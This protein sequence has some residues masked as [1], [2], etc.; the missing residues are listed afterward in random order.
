[1]ANN[2]KPKDDPFEAILSGSNKTSK[3]DPF[4]AILSGS[5][6][7]SPVPDKPSIPM[8]ALEHYGNTLSGGYLPHLQASAAPYMDKAL[9]LVTGNNVAKADALFPEKN[10]Y[11]S[12]RDENIARLKAEELANPKTALAA[13]A[14]GIVN[15][16]ALLPSA[17]GVKGGIGLGAALG[18]AQNPGDAPGIVDPIQAGDR[19]VNAG[20]GAVVGGT[21]GAAGN[22]LKSRKAIQPLL[23]TTKDPL[24]F[25]TMANGEFQN[26]LEKM[27]SDVI[28]P[29]S[30][31]LLQRIKGK[32]VKINPDD[33]ERAGFPEEA[34]NLRMAGSNSGVSGSQWEVP[35][36]EALRLKQKLDA[37][38]NWG[39]L[40]SGVDVEA[41]Q[42]QIESI[43]KAANDLR[44]QINEIPGAKRLN[45][46]LHEA[47]ALRSRVTEASRR[48]VAGLIT[49]ATDNLADM[50]RFDE[51]AGT[52][53]SDTAKR[54]ATA[55]RLSSELSAIH[56]FRSAINSAD[57]YGT[58]A[59]KYTPPVKALT[60]ISGQS[61]ATAAATSDPERLRS[62][63]ISPF[64]LQQALS[65][66][67]RGGH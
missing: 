65:A 22:Y 26:A 10:S 35:A 14:A 13:K 2:A 41:N 42:N 6:A 32:T 31:A 51:L 62:E 58:Q 8:T 53:L 43:S 16:A 17:G 55:K 34:K 20:A 7:V 23:E 67:I 1:M 49:K 25:Q 63:A 50:Q 47:L 57:Y 46:S 59:S 3:S 24:K 21:V 33:L 40:R 29:K 4:E 64:M 9:D 28:A 38:N 66:R 12:R 11:V 39:K 45:D 44:S 5:K 54:S 18:A 30:D 48:P 27:N 37:A 52:T 15:Q 19:A 60:G 56:P 36:E 61:L